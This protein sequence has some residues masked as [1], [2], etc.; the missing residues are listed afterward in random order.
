MNLTTTATDFRSC[1]ESLAQVLSSRSLSPLAWLLGVLL[2]VLM[3]WE[4]VWAAYTNYCVADERNPPSRLVDVQNSYCEFCGYGYVEVEI[5]NPYRAGT[6]APD[7]D[8][9][10]ETQVIQQWYN[11]PGPGGW[12]EIDVTQSRRNPD[13]GSP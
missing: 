10:Y 3:P 13:Y 9:P 1:P 12:Q 2:L 4:P 7:G 8:E 6:N 11:P 5:T